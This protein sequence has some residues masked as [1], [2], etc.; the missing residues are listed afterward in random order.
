[1]ERFQDRAVET[2]DG[3]AFRVAL[4]ELPGEVGGSSQIAGLD[5][6]HDVATERVLERGIFLLKGTLDRWLYTSFSGGGNFLSKLSIEGCWAWTLPS[7]MTT[8]RRET[9]LRDRAREEK[10]IRRLWDKADFG[11][12][13]NFIRRLLRVVFENV[14]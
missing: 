12:K 13:G 8:K 7:K 5:R 2:V 9:V 10:I 6:S 3:R 1:M 14:D 11:S 4:R